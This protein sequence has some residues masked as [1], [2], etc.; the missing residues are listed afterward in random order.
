MRKLTIKEIKKIIEAE[1]KNVKKVKQRPW[2]DVDGALANQVNWMKALKIK[3]ILG[4]R[5]KSDG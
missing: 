3:E 4:K 5:L 2:W 1:L